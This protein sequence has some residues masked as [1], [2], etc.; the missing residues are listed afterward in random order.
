MSFTQEMTGIVKWVAES[1]RVSSNSRPAI[2]LAFF[3]FVFI[4]ASS[5]ITY[6]AVS[7][8]TV[9]RIIDLANADRHDK[10]AS[11]LVKS[12]K[13]MRAAMKKAEDMFSKNYF[14][15]TSPEGLTPW[16]WLEEENYDYNYAGE[17]LAMDFISTEKMNKAWLASP[18]HRTNILNEKYTEIGVAV[19]EGNLN[20]HPTILAVQMFGSGDKSVSAGSQEKYNG[21]IGMEESENIFPELPIAREATQKKPVHQLPVITNPSSG[22]VLTGKNMEIAGRAEPETAVIIFENNFPVGETAADRNGWFHLT[23]ANISEGEH[24]LRASSKS[25]RAQKSEEELSSSEVDFKIESQEPVIRHRLLFAQNHPDGEYVFEVSADK[26]GCV[27]EI[28]R[29]K[30]FMREKKSATVAVSKKW[31]SGI[32]KIEDQAGNR[33]YEEINFSGLRSGDKQENILNHLAQYI[34]PEKAYAA[35]SGREAIAKNIGLMAM[36]GGNNF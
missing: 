1:R 29:K 26:S 33:T 3:C 24:R 9:K 36:M 17:N 7:D 34:W 35:D 27:L 13:L 23:V 14:S 4:V 10:R 19:L 30:I 18:T 11:D 8:I 32:L 22:S 20:D 31:L 6:A 28:G 25:D 15:H 5:S 2:Y 12:E 21:V 16:H